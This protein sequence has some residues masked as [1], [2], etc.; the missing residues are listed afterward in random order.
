MS[1]VVGGRVHQDVRVRGVLEVP[2]A[3]PEVRPSRDEEPGS[4]P[5]A[6]VRSA[7]VMRGLRTDINT[8]VHLT[9][10]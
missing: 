7:K 10:V 6:A 9:Y 4:L 5:G 3:Q 2:V 8:V 1:E